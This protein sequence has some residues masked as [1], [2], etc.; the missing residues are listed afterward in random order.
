MASVL[1]RDIQIK[2]E[3][4][5]IRT[6]SLYSEVGEMDSTQPFYPF[7]T[8]GEKGSWFIFGN[9]ELAAKKIQSVVLKGTWN[10]IPDGGYTLLY[11]DYDLEQPIKNGS[12]KAICE[13]QENSKW[14]VCGNSPIQLFETD[15][16]RNVKEDVELTLNIADNS[17][18][19]TNNSYAYTKKANG[20]YRI[21]LSEPS[22]GFGMDV[23]RKQFAEVMVYNSKA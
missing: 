13:W 10:K 11:K 22:I 3:V 5:D 14:N 19:G 15:K 6:F 18:L 12:F 20:F 1:F 4:S 21:R 2:V 17:L 8:T 23:Y 9:E 7:G 16:N